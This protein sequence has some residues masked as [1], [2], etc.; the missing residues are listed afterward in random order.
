MNCR[1]L[2]P[3]LPQAASSGVGPDRPLPRGSRQG[4]CDG[5]VLY[6]LLSY[7]PWRSPSL[8]ITEEASDPSPEAGFLGIRHSCKPG[9]QD[10]E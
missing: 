7:R 10:T 9:I 4:W 1:E 5:Q 6:L 3:R 8:A 2:R